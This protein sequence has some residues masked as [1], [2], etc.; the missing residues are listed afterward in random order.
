[1]SFPRVLPARFLGRRENGGCEEEALLL[2][3][4]MSKPE[5]KNPSAVY[6][7]HVC[8]FL[9]A[10]NSCGGNSHCMVEWRRAL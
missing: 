1:M 7:A 6:L 10:D 9:W 2:M 5:V 8:M 4:P 3:E